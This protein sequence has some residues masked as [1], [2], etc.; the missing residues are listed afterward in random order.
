MAKLYKCQKKTSIKFICDFFCL[1]YIYRG[2]GMEELR[3][4]AILF[5]GVGEHWDY[6]G[7]LESKL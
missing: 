2:C 3:R 4:R 6:L 7:E 1:V 5:H